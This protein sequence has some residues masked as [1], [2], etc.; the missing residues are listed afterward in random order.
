MS[1][2][3]VAVILNNKGVDHLD[4][5]RFGPAIAS[6]TA[7][8]T[9]V[10]TMLVEDDGDSA[11]YPPAADETHSMDVEPASELAGSSADTLPPSLKGACSVTPNMIQFDSC[12][13]TVFST[14]IS[15]QND[16]SST[17]EAYN[18][19]SFGIMFNL[20]LAHHLGGLNCHDQTRE[21]KLQKALRLYEF[22]YSIQMQEDLSLQLVYTLGMMNNLGHI[23]DAL[24][25]KEKS[26]QC[27]QHL[28][29]TLMFV[30]EGQDSGCCSEEMELFLNNVTHLVLRETDLA[31]AA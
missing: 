4:Q 9:N 27:Y 17:L 22:A 1:A 24:G 31:P 20:A 3:Q 25:D 30:M 12:R 21:A 5:S 15:I 13:R 29:S 10:K 28:L 6:F 19:F 16:G 11:M 14:P 26:Q 2:A 8:L 7:A 23:Q 18:R